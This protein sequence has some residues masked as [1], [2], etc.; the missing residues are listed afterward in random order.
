M[1]RTVKI[2]LV[3]DIEDNLL[4][5]EA[6]L[7]EPDVEILKAFS[8]REALE[9]LLLHDDVALA[10]LDVQMPEMDGF[11]LAELMRGTERTRHIPIIFVTAGMREQ[12]RVFHGY[13]SGAVDFLFKP[14]EPKILKHKA[15]VFLELHRQ[16][17]ALAETLRLN[18]E[19]LAVVGHD[20]RNPLGAIMMTAELLAESS[21]DEA[22]QRAVKRLRSSGTR[23]LRM[24]DELLD[25]SRARLGGGI[26][27]AGARSD[28]LVVANKVTTEL[29][30]AHP[31]RVIEVEHRG[32]PHG[33]WD[34]A[35]LEQ[36]ASNLVGNAI[37]HG[38]DGEPIRVCVD[39]THR[40][41]VE[42]AVHNAGHVDPALVPRLF[43]P[44]Q[45]GSRGRKRT[46]GL[47]LGLYIVQQIALA[48]GGA[49]A[50]ESTPEAGTTFRVTLPRE[51]PTRA[52]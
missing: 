9:L 47:G 34:G 52:A 1:S 17:Q 6:L 43:E 33:T 37:R 48:H 4:A 38:A 24:L 30:A 5:L 25:L 3:D 28:L 14:I 21:K 27:V 15:T 22:A 7:G 2:L 18:E 49:V 31:D 32:D 39:G 44:F 50:V 51:I 12:N 36:V 20:L 45:Q 11:E 10:F 46:E 23:M 26:P 8:G 42:L 40:D 16:K 19:L 41:S 29:Q 35:R 13:D